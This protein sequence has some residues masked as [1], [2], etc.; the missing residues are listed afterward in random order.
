MTAPLDDRAA[1]RSWFERTLESTPVRLTFFLA[2]VL[3]GLHPIFVAPRLGG[4]TLDWQFFQFFDEIARKTI[5]EFGQFPIW[6][7]YFCGGTTLVG[8]P[9]TTY[10][11]PTFPLVLL[12]GTT[13]GERLSDIP[14]LVLGCEGGYRL[15]RH[16]GTRG[17]A[18]LLC[19]LAFPFFG[20]TF[21]WMHD[22]QHGLA[23][24][25]LSTWVL[26]GYLRGLERPV[27]LAL[28]GAFFAWLICYRGIET[29]PELALGLGAWAIL[30]GRRRWID[31]RSLGAA[32]WPLGACAALGL[33]ALAFAGLRMLP[34]LEVVLRHPRIIKETTARLLGEVT[35]DLY[36]VPPGTKGFFA[37]G[38]VYVGIATYICFLGSFLFAA[39]RRRAAIPLLIT[40]WFMLLSLGWHGKAS[41]LPWLH[42]LPLFRSLR[43]PALWSVAGAFFLIISAS[44]GIDTFDGWLRRRWPRLAAVLVPLVVLVTAGEML[45]QGIYM[46][47]PPR[48]PFTW[49]P[50]V[51][52]EQ[53]FRQTRGNRFVQPLWPYVDRGSL[54]CYDETPWPASPALKP[55]LAAEEYLADPGAG[56]LRRLA[57]SPNRIELEADLLRPAT[58]LVN[59]NYVEGWRSSRGRVRSADGL[60]AV[61]LPAG[62]TRLTLRVWPPLCTWGLAA[63]AVALA[64]AF[65]LWR[66]DRRRQRAIGGCRVRS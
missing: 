61:D 35:F 63:M 41:P 8:N 43:N 57:W 42:E 53:E 66:R 27:Y 56:Q 55:D 18:A 54:N 11:V 1:W 48:S 25:A 50:A 38:Y 17:A 28:G 24:M 31:R 26:Y 19:A 16:L 14:V 2:L 20:R 4:Y 22:G 32:L 12:F 3:I 5:L 49:G 39:A 40:L 13:F 60:V 34:V 10:L 62:K 29:G 47:A 37:S 21:A 36:A 58:V 23:G 51:V 33:F 44:Y 64:A 9:Q 45:G 59:Q 46:N 7:P 65:W 52:V 30:E 6:N 15:M